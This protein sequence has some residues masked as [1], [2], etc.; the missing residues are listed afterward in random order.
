V[1]IV[2]MVLGAAVGCG[3][4]FWPGYRY[5]VRCRRLPR[6]RYWI[7]NAVGM[8][9]GILLATGA[10]LLQSDWLWF[11]AVGVRAGSVTGRKW[12]LGRSVGVLR[13]GGVRSAGD[14][15]PR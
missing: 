6:H 3:G 10:S 1:D 11:A 13:P 15:G 12:G 5:G 8:F 7:A 9:A 2:Y 14:R 4:A